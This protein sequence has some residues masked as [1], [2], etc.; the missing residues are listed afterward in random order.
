M[1]LTGEKLKNQRRG[2]RSVVI[3]LCCGLL[4]STLCASSCLAVDKLTPSE[5]YNKYRK[6]LAVATNIESLTPFLSKKVLDEVN[7]TPKEM[8]GTMF[9]IMKEMTPKAVVV[10]EEKVEG[11]HATL[12]LTVPAEGKPTTGKEKVTEK[13]VGTVLFVDEQGSWKIDKEKW[14]TKITSQ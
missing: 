8:K 7:T 14:D 1:K 2:S 13:T 6:A 12:S 4:Y 9:S 5:M 10:V 3:A 11:D